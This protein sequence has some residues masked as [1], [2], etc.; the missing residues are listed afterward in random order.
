MNG[1]RIRSWPAR[2]VIALHIW[3]L[4]FAVTYGMIT[5]P[6]PAFVARLGQPHRIGRKRF[7]SPLRLSR[8]VDLTL[9]IGTMRPTCLA[10]SLVLF[11][12][13]REQGDAAE[14]VI[15]LPEHPR[16]HRAHAWVELDGRDVGPMPGRSGH[17]ALARFA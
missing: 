1:R 14:I 8:A 15:G 9:R 12:L 17:Q 7:S 4:F 3:R 5:Q 13:L 2:A 6:L 10:R 16:D 11:R